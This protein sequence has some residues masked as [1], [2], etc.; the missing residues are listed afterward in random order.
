MRRVGSADFGVQIVKCTR[1]GHMDRRLPT[2]RREEPW[3]RIPDV[4]LGVAWGRLA[5]LFLAALAGAVVVIR[6]W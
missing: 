6:T 5:T 4:V 2:P 1:C 3:E